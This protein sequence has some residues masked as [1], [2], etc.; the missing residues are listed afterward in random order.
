MGEL[1]TSEK[2]VKSYASLALEPLNPKIIFFTST[3]VISSRSK[4][5]C[6]STVGLGETSDGGKSFVMSRAL[7]IKY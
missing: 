7:F 2:K 6:V 4:T 5:G 1:Y 3:S